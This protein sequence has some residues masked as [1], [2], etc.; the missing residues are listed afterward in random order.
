MQTLTTLLPPLGG[1]WELSAEH[2]ADGTYT[3]QASQ[4]NLASETGMSEPVTFSVRHGIRPP[5]S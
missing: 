5:S 1:A 4:T 3:A 2:L